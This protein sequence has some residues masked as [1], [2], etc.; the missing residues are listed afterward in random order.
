MT[1]FNGVWLLQL[2][3]RFLSHIP[4]FPSFYQ[5]MHK[6]A[7]S[8][9]DSHRAICHKARL[10]EMLV[11][12]CSNPSLRSQTRFLKSSQVRC[13]VHP[14]C[15]IFKTTFF[16]EQCRA[17][18]CYHLSLDKNCLW[19]G[20]K[21]CDCAVHELCRTSPWQS[22]MVLPLPVPNLGMEAG[23]STELCRKRLG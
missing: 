16:P 9:A 18:L 22:C 10:R 21:P 5:P 20:P 2:L 8:C 23:S 1:S 7:V 3:I 4:L 12:K 13:G 17:C 6:S 19:E 11:H 14:W 15:S